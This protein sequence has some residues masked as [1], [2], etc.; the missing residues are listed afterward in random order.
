[1]ETPFFRSKDGDM[2]DEPRPKAA[3]RA[4]PELKERAVRMV[5]GL[6]RLSSGQ[7]STASRPRSRLPRRPQGRDDREQALG[8]RADLQGPAG[9]PPDL[10]RTKDPPAVEQGSARRRDEGVLART[11]RC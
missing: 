5:R 1:M 3:K 10:L 11:L 2:E 8:G 7:S 6:R 9:R 4:D